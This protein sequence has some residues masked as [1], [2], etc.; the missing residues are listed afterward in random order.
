MRVDDTN[1]KLSATPYRLR[2]TVAMRFLAAL[3]AGAS[4]S[5]AAALIMMLMM[6]LLM[7][8]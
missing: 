6:P 5:T 8:R 3:A 7:M 1:A 4:T 2:T